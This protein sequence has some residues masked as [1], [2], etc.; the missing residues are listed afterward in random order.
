MKIIRPGPACAAGLEFNRGQQ[1]RPSVLDRASC[2]CA[3]EVES[4]PSQEATQKQQQEGSGSFVVLAACCHNDGDF[5]RSGRLTEVTSHPPSHP[6][7]GEKKRGKELKGSA[8]HSGGVRA[9]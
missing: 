4:P 5:F 3:Y 8:G 1:A 9:D 2:K 6:S 7:A